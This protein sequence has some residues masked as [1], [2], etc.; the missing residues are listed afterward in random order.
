M[1]PFKK[2]AIKSVLCL[3]SSR[4]SAHLAQFLSEEEMVNVTEAQNIWDA[5]HALYESRFDLIFMDL[6]LYPAGLGNLQILDKV[7][8]AKGGTV[9]AKIPVYFRAK[10][11][12]KN[13]DLPVF[14]HLQLAG[15]PARSP[16]APKIP[17]NAHTLWLQ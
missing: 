6:N 7:L 14:T 16:R 15:Q 8:A 10:S 2:T 12:E 9:S 11:A 17:A 3:S 5:A 13:L 4:A 1:D